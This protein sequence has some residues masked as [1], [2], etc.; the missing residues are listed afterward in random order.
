MQ[1]GPKNL[2]FGISNLKS[3]GACSIRGC[4]IRQSFSGDS[5]GHNLICFKSRITRC[6]H[7]QTGW[8]SGWP[9]RFY[10]FSD[11]PGSGATV[12]KVVTLPSRPNFRTRG[13]QPSLGP[14]FAFV[15]S[16]MNSSPRWTATPVGDQGRAAFK[17]VSTLPSGEIFTTT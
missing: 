13:S 7:R 17:T 15:Y 12:T 1:H 2:K 4:D 6:D 9:T 3:A 11:L 16:R 8:H 5:Q 14:P 10:F